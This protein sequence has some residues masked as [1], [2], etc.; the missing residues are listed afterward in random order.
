VVVYGGADFGK[1]FQELSR[2]CDILVATPGRL[3]DMIERGKVSLANCHFL[4]LDEADRMLDMGFE[5]QIRHIVEE[6]D[7]PDVTNRQ[8]LMFSATFPK[9]IQRLATDFLKD[10]IFLRVGR[11]G[12]TNDFITQRLRF[13]EE[14]DKKEVLMEVLNQIEGL[15]LIF[16]ETKRAADQLEEFLYQQGYPTTSIHGDR[17]QR[18]REA[19]LDS[20]RSGRTPILVATDVAA[21]GLHIPQVAHVV[22]YDMPNDVTDYVHRIGR[23]GR[24]GHAGIATGFFN[25]KNRGIA[26]DLVEILEET[27]QEIPSWLASMGNDS[28]RSGGTLGSL[29]P[30]ARYPR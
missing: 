16:V 9:P 27:T 12:S 24:A 18:E 30:H 28:F 29:T 21:R 7:M 11:L 13:V 26:R 20:F 17:S 14:E 19:A 23:T 3:V 1:Q 10:Y 4:V 15:T 2:G 25:E 5:K 8:T 6:N 22:N